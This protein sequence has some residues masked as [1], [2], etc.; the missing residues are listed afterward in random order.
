MYLAHN[1]CVIKI[2]H[3]KRLTEIYTVIFFRVSFLLI[4]KAFTYVV[5]CVR[6]AHAVQL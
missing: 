3:E 6:T 5:H 4:W 2:K 1:N